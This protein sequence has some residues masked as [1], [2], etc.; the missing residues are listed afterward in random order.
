MGFEPQRRGG[1]G[2][3]A[4][5]FNRLRTDQKDHDRQDEEAA[6]EFDPTRCTE[7]FDCVHR[8]VQTCVCRGEDQGDGG[9]EKEGG[10]M[11][12]GSGMM[13]DQAMGDEYWCGGVTL[14]R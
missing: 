7:G 6:W 10:R 5:Y 2:E 9:R 11:Y 12:Q 3:Y 14:W 4:I 8:L 13:R 1:I